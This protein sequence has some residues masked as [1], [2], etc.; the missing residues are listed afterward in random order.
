MLRRTDG[1][2]LELENPI[3]LEGGPIW[4]ALRPTARTLNL[5]VCAVCV[6][7]TSLMDRAYSLDRTA[8][9]RVSDRCVNTLSRGRKVISIS[10]KP[11]FQRNSAAS[12]DGLALLIRTRD[13]NQGRPAPHARLIKDHNP[14]KTSR[15]VV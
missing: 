13:S 11:L 3:S 1:R 6:S 9:N 10:E 8:L 2:A 4:E 5:R 7:P 14:D 15:K 12:C